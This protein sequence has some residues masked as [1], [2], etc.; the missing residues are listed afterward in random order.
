V[1]QAAAA[2][3]AELP[4]VAEVVPATVTSTSTH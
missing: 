3:R 1:A 4:E 2:V